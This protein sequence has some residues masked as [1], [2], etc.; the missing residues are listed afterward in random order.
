MSGNRSMARHHPTRGNLDVRVSRTGDRRWRSKQNKHPQASYTAGYH[1]QSKD[2][3]PSIRK[4]DSG[5][6]LLVHARVP[7]NMTTPHQP[8]RDTCRQLKQ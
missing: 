7:P 3:Q 5:C 4:G 1:R 6:L 8:S 2:F